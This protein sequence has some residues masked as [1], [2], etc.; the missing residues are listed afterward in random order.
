M[1][2]DRLRGIPLALAQ[3]AAYVMTTAIDFRNYL[4]KLE[5]NLT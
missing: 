3:A 2:V 5:T 4:R 1:I